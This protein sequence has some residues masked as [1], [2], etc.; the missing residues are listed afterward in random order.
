MSGDRSVAWGSAGWRF[1]GGFGGWD[2]LAFQLRDATGID[3]VVPE[4]RPG[5]HASVMVRIDNAVG[6]QSTERLSLQWRPDGLVLGTYPA[7]LMR[8]A[9]AI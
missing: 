7:E 2:W 4:K 6:S 1:S 8:Q 3:E 5:T 9:E